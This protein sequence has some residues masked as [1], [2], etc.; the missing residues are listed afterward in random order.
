M[1]QVVCNI[2][3]YIFESIPTR[4][5]VIITHTSFSQNANRYIYIKIYKFVCV[6]NLCVCARA[7]SVYMHIKTCVGIG[8]KFANDLFKRAAITQK[9]TKASNSGKYNKQKKIIL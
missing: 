4:F 7:L 2:Y 9:L 3:I 8:V 5:T 6:Y 1:C